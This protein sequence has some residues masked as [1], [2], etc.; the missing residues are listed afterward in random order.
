[1]AAADGNID[2]REA[3]MI[4]QVGE[5]RGIERQRVDGMISA[6]RNNQLDPP[7][8]TTREQLQQWLHA[9]A[10]EAWADGTLAKQEYAMLLGTAHR[11]GLVD[12]DVRAIIQR[13]RADVLA[14]AKS[15]LR[16]RAENS[17]PNGSSPPPAL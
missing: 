4:H 15:A 9:M 17:L 7:T 11:A 16:N 1:M 12:Y 14:E 8:P 5:R 3:D 13:A 10:A 6:A 2:P